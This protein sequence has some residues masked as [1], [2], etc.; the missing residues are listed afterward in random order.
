MQEDA[1]FLAQ[2]LDAIQSHYLRLRQAV[3]VADQAHAH[4]QD[5]L[6]AAYRARLQTIATDFWAQASGDAAQPAGLPTAVRWAVLPWDDAAWAAYAPAADAPLPTAVRVGR[7]A[8]EGLADLPAL[9]PLIGGG[10]T[11]EVSQTSKVSG[12][13]IFLTG[14]DPGA[15]RSLLQGLLLRLMVAA[16]PGSLRLILA[17]PV[18]LGGNLAAFMRLPAA[19]R[20]DKVFAR[21]EEIERQLDALVVEIEAI[22]QTRLQNV[23]PSVVEYNAEKGELA[24]PYRVL[25][26]ADFP[27]GCSE[28]MA[29]RLLH[30]ARN[31]PRA[32]VYILASL[33]AAYPAPRNFNQAELTG[34]GTVLRLALAAEGDHGGSPLLTWGDA[35]PIT[36]DPLPPAP[37]VNAWLEAVGRAVP[38]PPSLDFRRIA[39]PEAE[40]WLGSTHAGLRVAIGFD[41]TGRPHELALGEDASIVH[42]GL[43]GGITQSGKTNLLH[44]L[45]TQLALRY[46]PEELAL[47]L[48]DF[49]EGVGFQ[50]Y[51]GLPH[52]RAVALESEREFGLS[53]LRRLRDEMEARGRLYKGPEVSSLAE[54]RRQT[55]ARLPRVVLVMD[56]FQLL[57]GEDDRLAQE[58]GRLLEDLV[59]RGAAFGIHVLLSSQS[60]AMAG[61]YGNRIY[62]QMALRVALRCRG[63]DAQAILGEG[64]DAVAQLEQPGEA[65][66]NDEMGHKEQNIRIRAALL[67]PPE[68][69]RTLEV[70]HALAAPL[71]PAA[72]HPELVEG[73]RFDTL[74]ASPEPAAGRRRAYPPPV[75]FEGRAPARLAANPELQALLT[76][77]DSSPATLRAWLGEP[78]AIQPPIAAVFERYI[79]SNL[80][81]LGGDEAE[82]TGLLLAALLS[83]AACSPSPT[84]GEGRGGGGARFAVADFARPDAPTA[85]FFGRVAAGLP[86]PV[87]IVGP[88]QAGGMLAQL[89]A[90]LERW[91]RGA[92]PAGPEVFFLVAGLHRWR[93]LRG[94]DAYVQSEAAKQLTR[95]AEEGPDAGIHLIAWADGFATLER[96]FKRG[97]VGHFDLRVA[98]HLP[99]KDSNDLLGSN[100]AAKLAEGRGLF[101]HEE[102]ELG[103]LEKFKPYAVPEAEELAQMLDMIRAQ[104]S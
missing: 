37:Q 76:W 70:I 83:L 40:R 27:A 41:S 72:A 50:S 9:V 1:Q 80:L 91:A 19:W 12:G 38:P 30:I 46:P 99:E 100:A 29:E 71:E 15:L 45:I 56:E 8:V 42:H 24:V 55:G 32:G 86:H 35:Y 6:H 47:Y 10:Q 104:A 33:N 67:T 84:Q 74:S 92:E 96:V 64:N 18:G 85:G 48:V 52:A 49:K 75:T 44:V 23:Y 79:R 11:F 22:I 88:R 66:Y 43:I 36:P 81:I 17:D 31:G 77:P 97:G 98:L 2:A 34:L 58:A 101:R 3:A 20:G 73:R 4:Y 26:L 16:P 69:R 62:N 65:I 13:H 21:A 94:A 90:R 28:R 25:A 61:L 93:E 53:V 14:A 82:A 78:I 68:R 5:D 95:L 103:R 57:F 7:L 63:Q 54:Y 60:P 89:L 102:W 59:R 39:I 87:E 51:L